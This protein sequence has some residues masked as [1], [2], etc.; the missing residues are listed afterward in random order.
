MLTVPFV[1]S[2][3][4]EPR[5]ISLWFSISKYPLQAFLHLLS[6]YTGE[7]YLQVWACACTGDIIIRSG[8]ERDCGEERWRMRRGDLQ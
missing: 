2:W 8:R 1:M 7:S 5:A 3:G 4:A 6:V